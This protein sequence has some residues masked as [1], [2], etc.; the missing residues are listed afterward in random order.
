M[1][2][3]ELRMAGRNY[4]EI[5]DALGYGDRSGA[6]RAVK[7]ALEHGSR[8]TVEH[9]RRINTRRINKILSVF[10]PRMLNGDQVAAKLCY[11]GISILR[12]MHGLDAPIRVVMQEEAN[13]LA[14]EL[15][16]DPEAI[17]KEAEAIIRRGAAG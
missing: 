6:Y 9:H 14:A 17:V 13:R 10:W 8:E 5:A 15:G 7:T 12:A 11:Q 3:L 2:A 16:L 1:Q 4:Q